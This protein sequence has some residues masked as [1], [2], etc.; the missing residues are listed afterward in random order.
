MKARRPDKRV[1]LASGAGLMARLG[2]TA[3]SQINFPGRSFL[4]KAALF[5]TDTSNAP[6]VPAALRTSPE[7]GKPFRYLRPGRPGCAQVILGSLI[8]KFGSRV[9]LPANSPAPCPII[10]LSDALWIRQKA[11]EADLRISSFQQEAGRNA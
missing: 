9:V 7:V 6:K 5:S 1:T 2:T 4:A 3:V 10:S 8:G 11:L